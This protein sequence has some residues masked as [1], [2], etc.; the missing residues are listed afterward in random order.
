MTA[1]HLSPFGEAA[2]T[3]ERPVAARLFD[4]AEMAVIYLV[5]FLMSGALLAPLF[6]PDQN[7]D[8]VPWLRTMWLPVYGLI[9]L[10]A[11]RDPLR[12]TRV[13]VGAVI[14]LTLVAWA[15]ASSRWSIHGD[16]SSRR[17]IALLFT[18]LFGLYLAAR[19]D[20]TELV[21]I[22]AWL[23]L[24][25]AAGSYLVSLA[26]PGLGANDPIHP[27]SWNGL[28]YEKNQMGGLMTHGALVCAVAAILDPA[29]RKLW[30]FGSVL[31]IGAV[32]MTDSTTSLLGVAVAL[33]TLIAILILRFGGPLALTCVWAGV[34]GGGA[35]V[36]LIT[37]APDLFFKL[38]G[39]DPS[40]TGR[41]EIWG[42]VLHRV[43]LHPWLGYG[44]GAVWTDPWGPAWF[45]R[46]EVKW[47]APTAHNGWLDVL[48]Q[49]GIVGL[50]LA[51]LYFTLTAAAASTRLFRGKEG[52]WAIPFV[53]IFALL[54][55][56]EST[57]LQYNGLPWLMYTIISAK[58]FEWRG[59]TGDAVPRAATVKLFPDE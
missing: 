56:S 19:L 29:K 25:L 39:K 31:C 15:F 52:L 36:G 40:L 43:E 20:W 10:L 41:T 37:L 34:A 13:A 24:F 46:H 54:S 18:T 27:G 7:P 28:W 21:K 44:F 58:L 33:G 53:A 17:S 22:L 35:F 38:I 14:A 9:G 45:I 1:A 48:L 6:S 2:E 30:I 32:V 5:L 11:L 3:A 55:V 16:I 26:F 59:L 50:A 8:A 4:M 47:N 49:L 51:A 57:L 23:F 12:M 42:A